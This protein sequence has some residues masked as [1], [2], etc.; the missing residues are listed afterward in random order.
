MKNKFKF[1]LEASLKEVKATDNLKKEVS[2]IIDFP[3]DIT[4]QIDLAYFNSI[5]V[6]SGTN[7]NNATFLHEELISAFGS[8]V[9]KAVDIEHEE[10]KIIGHIYSSAFVD[11]DYNVIELDDIKEQDIDVVKS[12]DLHIAIGSVVYND[13]FPGIVKEI[14]QNKWK[15]SMEAYYSYFD[16]MVGDYIMSSD[17]AVAMG[18]DVE[19]DSLYGMTAKV[20]KENI[21]IASGNISKVLRGIHF[22]GVGIVKEPANPKSVVVEVASTDVVLFNYDDVS[23]EVDTK[24]NDIKDADINVT[25][26]KVDKKEIS[27]ESV[28]DSPARCVSYYLEL[29]DEYVKGQDTKILQTN[30]CSKFSQTC[31]VAGIGTDPMCLRNVMMDMAKSMTYAF[32]DGDSC[33]ID[34]LTNRL[35]EI[36]NK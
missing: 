4:S 33:S 17:E 15:V 18:I 19:D 5:F 24:N 22:A 36:M 25:S 32:I 28:D 30:W 34:D 26:N 31:P 27:V 1:Y 9:S 13:R 20:V 6:S 14:A 23:H 11:N 2:S 35:I 3:D 8:I 10:D 16:I 7:L 21:V 29:R 12:S